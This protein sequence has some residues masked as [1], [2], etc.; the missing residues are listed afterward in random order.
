MR[1]LE[2][3]AVG[4]REKRGVDDERNEIDEH[5]VTVSIVIE[6]TDGESEF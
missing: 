5:G 2:G 4:E 6:V 1:E 3:L